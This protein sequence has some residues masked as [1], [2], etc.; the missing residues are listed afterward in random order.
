[1][2]KINL[3]KKNININKSLNNIQIK[4]KQIFNIQIQVLQLQ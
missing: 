2:K 1:M 4:E 3:K